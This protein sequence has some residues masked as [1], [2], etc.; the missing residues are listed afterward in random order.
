MAEVNTSATFALL[1][2]M[3]K[4]LLATVP[5]VVLFSCSQKEQKRKVLTSMLYEALAASNKQQAYANEQA[6]QGMVKDL[7]SEKHPNEPMRKWLADAEAISK[8]TRVVMD[9]LRKARLR[10]RYHATHENDQDATAIM[11][12]D[13]KQGVAYNLL[14]AVNVYS[15]E[16]CKLDKGL[17]PLLLQPEAGVNRNDDEALARLYFQGVSM[18]EAFAGLSHIEAMLLEYE[19]AIIQLVGARGCILDAKY[20]AI[21]AFAGA[22]SNIVTEGDTYRAEML[23]IASFPQLTQTMTVNGQRI[24]V[25]D[26]RGKV[27]FV[28]NGEGL[29]KQDSIRKTWTGTIQANWQGT[30]TLWR[31]R[32]PYTV[33]RRR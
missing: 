30:D 17:K 3:R 14:K 7:R 28:A 11:L 33:V 1:L 19:R 29:D 16:L 23:L 10:L 8:Q 6:I 13:A 24:E 5:L 20:D 31:M 27:E 2:P 25:E 4:L 12:G 22:R 9:S 32:V 15:A 21:A 18:R 26:G